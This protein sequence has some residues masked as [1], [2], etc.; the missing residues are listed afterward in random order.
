[1]IVTLTEDVSDVHL[2]WYYLSSVSAFLCIIV[3]CAFLIHVIRHWCAQH[4]NKHIEPNKSLLCLTCSYFIIGILSAICVGLI[5][6][7]VFTSYSYS[8]GNIDISSTALSVQC[9]IGYFGSYTFQILAKVVL[10]YLLL[11]RMQIVF[12]N[13]C[14]DYADTFYHVLYR[15]VLP[16]SSLTCIA[17]IFIGRLWVPSTVEWILHYHAPSGLLYC[18]ASSQFNA[19]IIAAFIV[20]LALDFSLTTTLVFAFLKSLHSLRADT[21]EQHLAEVHMT[22]THCDTATAT[23]DMMPASK[24]EL[25]NKGVS[26]TVLTENEETVLTVNTNN[27][28]NTETNRPHHHPHLSSQLSS[29]GMGSVSKLALDALFGKN[30][31]SPRRSMDVVMRDYGQSTRSQKHRLHIMVVLLTISTKITI[32]ACIAVL[33]TLLFVVLS[34]LSS[35][36][37]LQM[38]VD[39]LINSICVWLMDGAARKHWKLCTK[40]CCCYLCYR[41]IHTFSK[42]R[43]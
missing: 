12:R 31:H 29:G 7:N 8:I 9:L 13:S 16:V 34:L 23:D 5:R 22:H 30:S 27:T 14:Y 32:L 35:K 21:F 15:L 24:P 20:S 39:T 33:S 26:T 40:Y 28:S 43:S 38:C 37:S 3:N 36:V 17:L 1:M 19:W 6:S 2:F 4:Q 18:G 11:R 42:Q 25:E 41:K 10:Y